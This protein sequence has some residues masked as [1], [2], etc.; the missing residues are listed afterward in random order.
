M[1]VIGRRAPMVGKLNTL[2]SQ[3]A[4]R[5]NIQLCAVAPRVVRKGLY[6]YRS[7]EEADQQMERWVTDAMVEA[8]KKLSARTRPKT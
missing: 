8:D 1:R 2:P 5:T 3:E 4:I 7:H 6:R